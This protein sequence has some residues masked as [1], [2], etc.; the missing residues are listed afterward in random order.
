MP[1]EFHCNHCGKLVRAP[2]NAGGKH[3]QCPGCHQS[4]YVPT[5]SDQI[6]VLD[7]A[8]IDQAAE[9]EAQRAAREAQ[10]LAQR[11]LH[12]R[13]AGPERAADADAKARG[14][15]GGTFMP[16]PEHRPDMRRLVIDYALAMAS[17]SIDRAEKLAQEIRSDMRSAE[18]AIEAVTVDEIPPPELAK[19][20]RPVLN[21]FF[22]SLRSGK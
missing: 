1:I 9:R 7:V 2:D 21:G 22:R 13:D 12:E 11:L 18:K 5:P 20:P 17:S 14:A 10:Q 8:P 16:R 4:V 3:G 15:G 6:E 19:I